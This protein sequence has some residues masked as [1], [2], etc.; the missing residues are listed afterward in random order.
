MY[1]IKAAAQ[2]T[3][4]PAA[5]LRAWERRYGVG[6]T[7]RTSSGYRL[8]DEAA[9]AEVQAMQQLIEGGWAAMQAAAE[10]VRRRGRHLQD[11]GIPTALPGL[12][13][14]VD[15]ARHLDAAAM[16]RVLDEVLA[17]AT[18]EHVFDAWLTPA[19][20]AV[21]DAW[22]AGTLDVAGEHFASAAVMRR[23]SAAYEAAAAHA[24]GPRVLVGLPEGAVHEVAPLAM[25]TA[26]RRVGVNAVY[27]GA[28]L[29]AD[30]WASA[31]AGEG[32]A[33]VVMSLTTT[34]DVEAAQVV[35]DSLRGRRPDLCIAVGG[36]H[37]AALVGSTLLFDGTIPESARELAAHLEGRSGS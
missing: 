12:T 36:A 28:D 25:A 11:A 31:A 3:S 32:V 30:A 29:P 23:L 35:V 22:A 26:L 20:H 19:L 4:I 21:G 8:Y 2:M 18:F 7:Q 27:L 14:F 10:V 15:A 1:T 37:A 6:L 33:A 5:T 17:Q 13:A 34:A 24:R 16:S 9:L